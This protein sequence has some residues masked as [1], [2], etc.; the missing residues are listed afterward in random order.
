MIYVNQPSLALNSHDVPPPNI[1]MWNTG[2]VPAT[3]TPQEI[4]NWINMVA[5][6]APNRRLEAVV[7]NCHGFSHDG[8]LGYGLSIGTGI[9]YMNANCFEQIRGKT[10]LIYITACGASRISTTS[11]PGGYG[12]GHYLISSIA[13]YARAVV[14]AGTES[15]IPALSIPV[16]HIDSFEGLVTIYNPDGHLTNTI[17]HPSGTASGYGGN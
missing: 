9:N 4:M 3:K 2:I 11:R 8:Q 12:D 13:R 14:V 5:S 16:N 10:P 7:L 1:R 17:R 15:Q 6:S